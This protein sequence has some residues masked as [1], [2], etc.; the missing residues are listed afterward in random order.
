MTDSFAPVCVPKFMDQFGAFLPVP[1]HSTE[2]YL[3]LFLCRG[4][5]RGLEAVAHHSEPHRV[6]RTYEMILQGVQA[7]LKLMMIIV[8]IVLRNNCTF[9]EFSSFHKQIRVPT[10]ESSKAE[11]TYR[12][13]RI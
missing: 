12:A 6:P 3:I 7:L 8:F 1:V 10:P 13:V 2:R 4:D 9:K 11:F 5:K